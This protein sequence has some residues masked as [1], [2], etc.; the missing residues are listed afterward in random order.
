MRRSESGS[1]VTEGELVSDELS[2]CQSISDAARDAGFD[3]ILAPSAALPGE[4]TL[5]VFPRGMRRVVEEN[6]R[7]Q[8]P[9]R[10]LLRILRRVRMRGRCA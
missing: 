10:S 9:P 5:A 1:G 4:L 3:G 6:S 2:L 7:V 8:R